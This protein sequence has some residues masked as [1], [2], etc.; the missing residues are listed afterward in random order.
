MVEGIGPAAP[1]RRDD[2]GVDMR[3]AARRLAVKLFGWDPPNMDQIADILGQMG[4]ALMPGLKTTT[5]AANDPHCSQHAGYVLGHTPP[6][7]LCPM[8][9]TS[10]AD[11][12]IRTMVHEAAHIAGIGQPDGEA[13]CTVYDCESNCGGFSSAD[14]WS[15]YVH[16]LSGQTADP[17]AAHIT[18]PPPGGGGSGS[19]GHTP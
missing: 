18:A 17:P 3:D 13:Y 19:G 2:P 8:F 11:Q 5:A 10:S 14:V 12:Q 1:P 7:V 9:F 6:V 4:Q 15:N 16:C